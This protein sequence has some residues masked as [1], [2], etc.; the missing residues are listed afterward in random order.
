[1]TTKTDSASIARGACERGL[2]LIELLIGILLMGAVAA[3]ALHFYKAQNEAYLAQDVIANRQGNTRA[4]MGELTRQIRQAGY[5][6]PGAQWLRHSAGHDTLEIYLGRNL[7]ANVD[8]IRYFVKAGG[9][10]GALMKQIN[11]LPPQV[12]AEG[13]D[14]AF[15]VPA[16]P[17]PIRTLAIALVSSEQSQ[18]EATALTTRHRLGS[19]VSLRNR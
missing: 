15:F 8:T 16:G 14:S 2:T 4:A 19:T 7:G 3:A 10:A 17:A 11:T 18:F 6:V 9:G 12:F 1:M 5:L 13:I